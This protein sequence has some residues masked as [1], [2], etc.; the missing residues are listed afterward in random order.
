MADPTI[1]TFCCHHNSML[2]ESSGLLLHFNSQSYNTVCLAS[3]SIGMLGA[4]FQILPRESLTLNHRWYSPSATRGRHI[5]IWLAV[6]DLLASLGVFMRSF[7]FNHNQYLLDSGF[8]SYTLICA[9]SSAWIQYFYT[10]TWLWTLFYAIDMKLVLRE[11]DG[12]PMLYHSVVWIFPAIFTII[13]L[14]VLYIPDIDCH[15]GSPSTVLL[16]ILPNY[17]ATYFPL[18]TVMLLNPFLYLSLSNDVKISITRSTSQFTNKERQLIDIIKVKFLLINVSFYLCWLPNL[19]NGILIWNFW[20][21]VPDEIVLMLWY[22]MALMNP[23]QAVFNSL[24]YRRW[25]GMP[26]RVYM[27]CRKENNY[28]YNINFN[29]TSKFPPTSESSPLLL[30]SIN[31]TCDSNL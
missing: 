20:F 25:T 23:L 27:P 22:I 1:K 4:I 17:L 26:E 2:N 31:S 21:S 13:G 8:A 29:N 5:I 12:H 3:S 15:C 10:A 7:L 14:S 16:R 28:S 18:A 30:P 24:V 6:A 11:E 9:V 19:I